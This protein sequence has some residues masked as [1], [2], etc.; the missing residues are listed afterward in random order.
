MLT[1]SFNN[2]I[3]TSKWAV[4]R[5]CG[6]VVR[7]EFLHDNLPKINK[8]CTLLK[9]ST[10]NEAKVFYDVDLGCWVCETPFIE[11]RPLFQN[12]CTADIIRQL[13]DISAH[14]KQDNSYISL[15][16]DE[17]GRQT[18]PWYCT[19]LRKFMP[20]SFAVAQ[21]MKNSKAEI[22]IHG[23]FTLSN[24]FLDN[25]GKIVVLDFEN[26]SLGPVLWD[27]TTL[28]YSLVENRQYKLA[29]NLYEKFSC[30]QEMLLAIACVRLAQS[31]NKGNNIE[32]RREALSFIDGMFNKRD[33]FIF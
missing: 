30:G 27:E 7:K 21:W 18:V 1:E 33:K 20:G 28:V 2:V 3:H 11:L 32:N 29:L 14:W 23:D 9:L 16:D 17:W 10:G 22:F 25:C 13:K 6:S 8:E 19:L 12:G 26:A 4:T 24:V 31:L 5:S 15:V